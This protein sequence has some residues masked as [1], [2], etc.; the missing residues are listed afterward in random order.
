MKITVV[1]PDRP[2]VK[3]HRPFS[4]RTVQRW[5]RHFDDDGFERADRLAPAGL[6]SVTPIVV[7]LLSEID[8]LSPNASLALLRQALNSRAKGMTGLKQASVLTDWIARFALPIWIEELGLP[9]DPRSPIG[10]TTRRKIMASAERLRQSGPL[11][12]TTHNVVAALA[13]VHGLL[14]I[15]NEDTFIVDTDAESARLAILE[16]KVRAA[17]R[18]LAEITLFMFRSNRVADDDLAGAG[19][20]AAFWFCSALRHEKDVRVQAALR[21]IGRTIPQ[22]VSVLAAINTTDS[23]ESVAK[24]CAWPT[25]A[26]SKRKAS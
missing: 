26:T 12:S 4:I 13:E 9:G 19:H 20:S 7:G 6:K 15:L 8:A 23:F 5:F 17:I 25:S 18:E 24:L 21:M 2:P 16:D 14:A 22:L 11:L 3:S 10:A 1:R